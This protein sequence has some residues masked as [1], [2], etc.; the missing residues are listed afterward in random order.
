MAAPVLI[1][2]VEAFTHS[3]FHHKIFFETRTRLKKKRGCAEAIV[4]KHDDGGP[5][6]DGNVLKR[7]ERPQHSGDP[8]AA[9]LRGDCKVWH[10]RAR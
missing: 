2:Y 6:P 8:G 3:Y 7:K 1:I 9:E 4:T 10:T 5:R